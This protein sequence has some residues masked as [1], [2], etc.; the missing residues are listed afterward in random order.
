MAS[1]NDTLNLG[2]FR[3]TPAEGLPM[4]EVE[5]INHPE[6]AREARAWIETLPET[7]PIEHKQEVPSLPTEK[8]VLDKERLQATLAQE[9]V[10]RRQII[11]SVLRPVLTAIGIFVLILVVFKSPVIFSQLGFAFHKSPVTQVAPAI[12]DA[13]P[14]DPTIT[15]PKINVHAPVVYEPSTNEADFQKALEGGVVHYANNLLRVTKSPSIIKA[16][17]IPTKSP[18]HKSS[19]P[20]TSACSIPLPHQPSASLHARL[21]ARRGS[22]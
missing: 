18:A 21:L 19:C 20:P 3:R 2:S 8:L 11:P 13:I 12:A 4:A 9:P 15:I 22:G 1:G 14:A 6:A 16:N 7:F 5:T 10:A 17:V